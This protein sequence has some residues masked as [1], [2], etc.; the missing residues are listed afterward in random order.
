MTSHP[1]N[2]FSCAHEHC[3]LSENQP[4]NERR[5]WIVIGLTVVTMIVEIIAGLA[6]GSMALLADGW[7][8]ASHASALGL[9]AMAY[10]FARTYKNDPR[11]T[12][13]TGKI[14]EL[15]AFS[16]AL[17]LALIALLM[18]YESI[19]RLLSPVPIRFN[20]AIL[21]AV[22]GLAVNLASAFILNEKHSHQEHRHAADCGH[23]HHDH[24]LRAAYLHVLADALTSILAIIALVVGKFWGW[25]FLDPVMGIAGALLISRWSYGLLR[26]TGQVLL[27]YN[28]NQNLTA[29]IR[30]AINHDSDIRIEDLHVWRLGTGHYSA[31]ISLTTKGRETP[32]DFKQRLCH[33]PMLS[34]LT[35]EVNPENLTGVDS[36][37]R[38]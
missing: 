9:T 1:E 36:K 30:N 18:V 27:D 29:Q 17:L 21:V 38:N 5:T 3:F 12:F 4:A 35:I 13:G 15:A 32:E 11:F 28:S 37:K 8:M 6:F 25:A 16:S 34:H 26:Q 23:H 22:I 19:Q 10:Y 33:I 2:S 20:E 24:N 14:N 31:I 7:H